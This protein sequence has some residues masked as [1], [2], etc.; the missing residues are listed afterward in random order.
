MGKTWRD[1][2]IRQSELEWYR[3][4]LDKNIDYVPREYSNFTVT[5]IL[6]D[7]E[8]SVRYSTYLRS[9]VEQDVNKSLGTCCVVFAETKTL[10]EASIFQRQILEVSHIAW[11]CIVWHMMHFLTTNTSLETVEPLLLDEN[12]YRLLDKIKNI[13]DAKYSNRDYKFS[14]IGEEMFSFI[15][16]NIINGKMERIEKSE[17]LQE[18]KRKKYFKIGTET[19]LNEL[20]IKYYRG[21]MNKHGNPI[22]E[23]DEIINNQ[24]NCMQLYMNFIGSLSAIQMGEDLGVCTVIFAATYK[25]NH[26]S[27]IAK[28]CGELFLNANTRI[29]SHISRFQNFEGVTRKTDLSEYDIKDIIEHDGIKTISTFHEYVSN[30]IDIENEVQRHEEVGMKMANLVMDKIFDKAL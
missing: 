28:S 15:F 3:L 12:R 16:H 11:T 2:V 5:S 18:D 1:T 25:A 14:E 7:T 26:K 27:N 30:E 20:D 29:L 22:F 6:Q 4:I 23:T 17:D 9:L 21:L 24:L 8:N 19:D 13:I 10:K